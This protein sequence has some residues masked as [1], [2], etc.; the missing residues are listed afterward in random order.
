MCLDLDIIL[1]VFIILLWVIDCMNNEA[2]S[3]L[4]GW[5]LPHRGEVL[6]TAGPTEGA[7]AVA[8]RSL[9]ARLQEV[10]ATHKRPTLPQRGHRQQQGFLHT[11]SQS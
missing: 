4:Y 8:E 7:V 2:E 10:H 1:N 11:D 9:Q 6:Q 5:Q 3:G